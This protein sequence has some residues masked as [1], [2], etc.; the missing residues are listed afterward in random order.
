MSQGAWPWKT[1][2]AWLMAR[3]RSDMTPGPAGNYGPR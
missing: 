1:V 3:L 2:E